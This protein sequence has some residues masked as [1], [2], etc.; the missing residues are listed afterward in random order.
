MPGRH[1][2]ST[3]CKLFSGKFI[4]YWA[5][6]VVD[7]APVP[8][9]I[10]VW[11][12]LWVINTLHDPGSLASTQLPPVPSK[13]PVLN[14]L[15]PMAKGELSRSIGEAISKPIPY[16][17]Y[18]PYNS[19]AKY[20]TGYYVLLYCCHSHPYHSRIGHDDHTP[21]SPHIHYTEQVLDLLPGP[22]TQCLSIDP[23]SAGLT[24]L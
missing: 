4:P 14:A 20:A 17:W 5:V 12:I 13:A 21:S 24:F 1:I 23:Y 3:I 19:H 10:V 2:Y 9:L 22:P 16:A 6:G 7:T 11:A 8:R 15:T 18:C